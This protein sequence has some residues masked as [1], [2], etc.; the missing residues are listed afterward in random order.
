MTQA[1]AYSHPDVVFHEMFYD[2]HDA[3]A[4]VT[5]RKIGERLSVKHA[6]FLQEQRIDVSPLLHRPGQNMG[7]CSNR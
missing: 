4:I 2:A 6:S 5:V 7:H 3:L 1:K